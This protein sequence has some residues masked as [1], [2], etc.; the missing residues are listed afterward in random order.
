MLSQW[1][2]RFQIA[3]ALPIDRNFRSWKI[4]LTSHTPTAPINLARKTSRCLILQCQGHITQTH[5]LSYFGEQKGETPVSDKITWWMFL[6]Y[7]CILWVLGILKFPDSAE[8]SE[9]GWNS[10]WVCDAKWVMSPPPSVPQ[11]YRSNWSAQIAKW[12]GSYRITR[13]MLLL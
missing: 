6:D 12:V 4:K 8:A 9:I 5:W 7:S 13:F 3:A 1:T 10:S 2:F 11:I